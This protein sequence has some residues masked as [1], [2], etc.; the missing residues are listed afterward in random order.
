MSMETGRSLK[1]KMVQRL[2]LALI[3]AIALSSCGHGCWDDGPFLYF[4]DGP[5]VT[6]DADDHVVVSG[7]LWSVVP[8]HEG[9]QFC[10]TADWAG[11]MPP[12]EEFQMAQVCSTGAVPHDTTPDDGFVFTLRSAQPVAHPDADQADWQLTVT[13]QSEFNDNR[14]D[15]VFEVLPVD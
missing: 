6:R 12:G 13:I 11:A 3:V 9:D 8:W 1:R 15:E 10:I 14:D 7:E 2:L 5:T 4:S